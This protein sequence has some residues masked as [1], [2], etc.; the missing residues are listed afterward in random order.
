MEHK[1]YFG[2]Y[3]H[4]RNRAEDSA[5]KYQRL[6]QQYGR[7]QNIIIDQSKLIERLRK[8]ICD[9]HTTV[10]YILPPAEELVTDISI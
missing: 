4:Q 8:G 9:D 1:N 5:E 10:T 2:L 3:Y 6:A 7:Q